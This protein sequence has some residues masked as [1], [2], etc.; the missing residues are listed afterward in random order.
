MRGVIITILASHI[1]AYA[2]YDGRLA[3]NPYHKY[4]TW[5]YVI[6]LIFISYVLY[7]GVIILL[8]KNRTKLI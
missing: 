3:D 8:S 2:S 5:L 6:I 4:P 1:L 7:K